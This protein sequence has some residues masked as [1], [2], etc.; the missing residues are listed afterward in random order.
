MSQ[1]FFTGGEPLARFD[2]L[3]AIT[4]AHC[5]RSDLWV[6]TSGRGLT[7]G[8][9]QRLRAAGLTGILFSLEHWDAAAHDAFRGAPRTFEAVERGA[10]YAREAG[11]VAGL[12]FCPVR[13]FVSADSLERYAET[14]RRLNVSFIQI[15][16]PRAV[17]HY[18][19][20]DVALSA[21]QIGELEQW[22]DRLNA[23]P[24]VSGLPSVAY[25]DRH[26]RQLGCQGAGDR[27]LYVDTE[28]ELQ[29]C[30]YCRAPGE[31]ALAGDLTT[32]ISRLRQGGCSAAPGYDRCRPVLPAGERAKQSMAPA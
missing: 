3:I 13:E 6:I 2:D 25:I 28:G 18:A 21:E 10:A 24:D 5:A 16:E 19:G 23:A 26:N 17:G 30:P 31:S 8:K 27:Y 7:T 20:R 22:T 29:A 11:L 14:A 15:L 1:I 12:S 4:E 9:A 32:A